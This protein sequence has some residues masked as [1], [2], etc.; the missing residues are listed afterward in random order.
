VGGHG[1][2]EG[3]DVLTGP[4]V[5]IVVLHRGPTA[6]TVWCLQS[7][8]AAGWPGRGT[9]LV[10]D[11]TTSFDEGV[12]AVAAPLD[13]QILRPL[14]N[15]GFAEGCTLGMSGAVERG[16]AFVLLLNNDAVADP[17]FRGP[18]VK[19]ASQ[20]AD[21]GLVSPRSRP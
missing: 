16:A 19:A 15:L 12:A 6:I 9:V 8:R 7:L 5:I 21:A 13:V 14:R 18:L 17:D 20:R 2:P 10:V 3:A 4:H 11:N 1:G